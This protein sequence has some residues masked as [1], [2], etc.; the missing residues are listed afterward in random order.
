MSF[1]DREPCPFGV[2]GVWFFV[3]VIQKPQQS[4]RLPLGLLG[5]RPLLLT[6]FLTLILLLM[7]VGFPD[8]RKSGFPT[9]ESLV[10]RQ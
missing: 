7:E 3:R 10:S 9:L 4:F 2:G 5:R 1:W 6:L 8:F